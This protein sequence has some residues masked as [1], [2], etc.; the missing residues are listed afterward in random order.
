M[1]RRVLR[2]AAWMVALLCAG[3][4]VASAPIVGGPGPAVPARAF[5]VGIDSVYLTQSVQDYAG[6]VPLVQGRDGLLRV[7]LV[8]RQPNFAAPVVRVHMMDTA[9]NKPVQSY[10][11]KSPLG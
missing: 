6:T 2:A 7:F 10:T 1:P 4:Q 5:Y 11:A 3:C 8:A 9:T